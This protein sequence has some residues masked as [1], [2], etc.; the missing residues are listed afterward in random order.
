MDN[1]LI[2]I[3]DLV[4]QRL[5]GGEE[6]Q[7]DGAW[8]RMAQLLEKEEDRKP[9]VFFWRRLMGY[10]GVVLLL[11]GL[12]V[13]GYEYNAYRNGGGSADGHRTLA[14][15]NTAPQNDAESKAAQGDNHSRMVAAADHPAHKAAN[16]NY[17]SVV[18]K[19]S[20]SA[21]AATSGEA[22]DMSKATASTAPLPITHKH[23][24]SALNTNVTTTA[25]ATSDIPA[26]VNTTYVTDAGKKNNATNTSV[27][28]TTA[29]TK[30]HNNNTTNNNKAVTGNVNTNATAAV[31]TTAIK[32]A[33]A[34]EQ[35]T[36]NTKISATAKNTNT[37]GAAQQPTGETNAGTG[38]TAPAINT[39]N[40]TVAG[41]TNTATASGTT[42]GNNA[43]SGHSK[44]TLAKRHTRTLSAGGHSVA[45]HKAAAT[46]NTAPKVA[47]A[48]VPDENTVATTAVTTQNTATTAHKADTKV[49]AHKASNARIRSLAAGNSGSKT[50][51]AVAATTKPATAA[52]TTAT[53]TTKFKDVI[54][55]SRK[56]SAGNNTLPPVKMTTNSAANTASVAK[57]T[58]PAA[59]NTMAD[60]QAS[61]AVAATKAPKTITKMM[62][63]ITVTQRSTGTFPGRSR[64][65]TDTI[66]KDKIEVTVAVPDEPEEATTATATAGKPAGTAGKSAGTPATG[67]VATT[68]A[69]VTNASQ[70]S[71]GKAST[72]S[73]TTPATTAVSTMADAPKI[74]M[75]PQTTVPQATPAESDAA[76]K[77]SSEAKTEA[78]TTKKKKGL[79]ALQG[80]SRMFN[81]IQYK[82]GAAQFAPGITAGVNGTFFG[83]NSFKGFQFGVVGAWE[84]DDKWS[85]M[86]EVKYFHRANNN[87]SMT[88]YYFDYATKDSIV[89]TFSFSTLHS[90]EV[91]LSIKYT[92]GRFNFLAGANLLYTLKVGTG[93]A[94]LSNALTNIAPGKPT[95][96]TLAESDF[97]GRFGI[98]YLF[99]LSYTVAPNVSFDLRTVQT[100]WD[101]KKGDGGVRVSNQL[102]KSPSMQ[103]SIIYKFGNKNHE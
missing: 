10:S 88:D 35:S 102:Y 49:N 37:A 46:H 84:L 80:L 32:T 55:A 3:D 81:E 78:S 71:A 96:P 24:A 34:A 2:N 31:T 85:L 66:L 92:A 25:P 97:G 36:A 39:E 59:A 5:S 12:S 73:A 54:T 23:S 95:A 42:V 87:F 74:A 29:K 20:S 13:G 64:I 103:F 48:H 91:P 11:A 58:L 83:P 50:R 4:R 65:V 6:A 67:A 79:H 17:A 82:V 7:R 63:R 14:D 1:N 57:N 94:P 8:M 98:G 89:N 26:V 56:V 30:S 44:G 60:T 61:V 51:K 43:S 22:I 76:A 101:S 21:H 100:M 18:H 15:N 45:A 38:S 93:P 68:N 16:S 27:A 75:A 33:A 69:A 19:G 72:Q 53:G 28:K 99:G 70:P 77:E 86:T 62:D 47:A 40:Q 90:F 41:N 52:K 9:V